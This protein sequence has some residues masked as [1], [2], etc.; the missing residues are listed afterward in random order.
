[1]RREREIFCVKILDREA[2]STVA[3]PIFRESIK[4]LLH[5][6][7]CDFFNKFFS[8]FKEGKR[9]YGIVTSA[10]RRALG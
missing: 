4:R 3:F 6:N 7:F 10:H 2:G 1:M 5:G 8:M 9:L